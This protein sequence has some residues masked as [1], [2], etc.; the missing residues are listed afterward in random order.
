MTCFEIRQDGIC[1]GERK[2]PVLSFTDFL[3]NKSRLPLLGEE[4]DLCLSNL[5]IRLLQETG[6]EKRASCLLADC[7]LAKM[8]M[9]SPGFR[10]V[11]LIGGKEAAG[12]YQMLLEAFHP[13]SS[14]L[15]L[16]PQKLFEDLGKADFDL[17][18]LWEENELKKPEE[19]LKALGSLAA[20]GAYLML[21]TKGD[22]LLKE[23]FFLHFGGEEYEL[24]DGVMLV[25]LPPAAEP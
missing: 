11:L 10:K 25:S 8:H 15:W 4:K 17:I 9:A 3:E 13:L 12:H 16:E 19:V 14:F 7:F 20:P 2:E 5:L 18:L 6:E 24:E 23:L 1:F 21:W 22:A